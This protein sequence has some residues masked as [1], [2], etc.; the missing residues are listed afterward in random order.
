MDVVEKVS[1]VQID[2]D[3]DLGQDVGAVRK[4]STNKKRKRERIKQTKCAAKMGVKLINNKWQVT[5][6]QSTTIQW[7]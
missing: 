2:V 5:S 1:P 3:S 7:L 4:T 6:L